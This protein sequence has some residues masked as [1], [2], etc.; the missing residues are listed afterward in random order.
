MK[1]SKY[2]YYCDSCYTEKNGVR[3]DLDPD[4]VNTAYYRQPFRCVKKEQWIRHLQ[5]N[6]HIRNVATS[7]NIK[8]ELI[9]ECKH[10]LVRLD[11]RSYKIHTQ[12]NYML[13]ASK[14]FDYTE[15]CSCNNFILEGKRFNT[16]EA[17][18]DY[19]KT[20]DS[21]TYGKQQKIDYRK[22]MYDRANKVL[23]DREN[24]VKE[25][26][27]ARQR[28]EEKMRKELA[29][30]RA[31]EAKELEEKRKQKAKEKQRQPPIEEKIIKENPITMTIEDEYNKLNNIKD[32]DEDKNDCNIKPIWDDDDT[33]C[34]CG[35][36]TNV[37]KEYPIEKLKNWEVKLCLC[38]DETDESETDEDEKII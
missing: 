6:K 20:K 14:C 25:L 29:E 17:L 33:C 22:A 8:D 7:N 36:H 3:K 37:W 15:E 23:E 2:I 4:S 21:Y 16:F 34:E 19:K 9:N 12:R 1:E 18:R 32:K 28:S 27:E 24:H 31:K 35:L 30:K 13:W 26:L 10:C 5:T 38:E 11:D